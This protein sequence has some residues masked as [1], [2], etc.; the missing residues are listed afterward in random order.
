MVPPV[1]V[2]SR[3]LA[4]FHRLA[5][6]A[7]LTRVAPLLGIA[8]TLMLAP[9]S[10]NL[11]A[12][13]PAI[14]PSRHVLLISVDGLH[15]S[16]LKQWIMSNPSS[17]LAALAAKGT[18]YTKASTSEP[19][20]SF[21]GLLALVTGASPKTTGVY[22]D[23]SYSRV[24]WAPGSNCAG[25]AGAETVY[26]EVLDAVGGKIPLFGSIQPAN[27]PMGKLDGTCEVVYPHSFLQTNTIFNV[28]HD[29]GLYTAW[30]DKHPA[31]EIVRGRQNTGAEDLFT[32][33][34]NLNVSA[35]DGCFSGKDPTKVSVAQTFCYD[36][37]KVQA[38][39]N[40]IDGRD[41]A[42]TQSEPVP[43]I[44]GMNFQA[45]SVAE[46][47]VDS[48]ATPGG[49]MPGTLVFTSQMNEALGDV[50][51]AIGQFWTELGAQG[52]Q[53]STELIITAKHGQSPIDPTKLQKIGDQIT[54]VLTASGTGVTSADIG[55]IT[56]DDVALIWLRDQSKTAAAV[57][58]L[59][60]DQEGSNT[61]HIQTILAG[62]ALVDQFGNP[63]HN[64][65]TP[66]IIVQPIPGTI[67]TTSG[68]KVAE[69]GGFTPDDTHVALL[70]VDGSQQTDTGKGGKW[71]HGAWTGHTVSEPVTTR[72]VAPTILR[73]L[74]IN[75]NR[76]DGVRAEHT[77][78]LPN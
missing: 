9:A 76:L 35:T 12:A 72:Q 24:L 32:P 59:Q 37:I 55:Q 31:Y 77:E 39:L 1:L 69:H 22:Y 16:D 48:Y 58:A 56:E 3:L 7:R 15:A 49:Y 40:E 4:T 26:S 33:E 23:D 28:A 29:A 14:A 53:D 50:D 62:D 27:L 17:N 54:T 45:V 10:S 57:A 66:D 65:R 70:V 11:V 6:A 5:R 78:E 73:Y 34:I 19:S 75:P 42:N 51:G 67:Y 44:F 30:S 20:D 47:L 64:D 68:S 8:A 63:A 46:K 36:K 60:K 2:G 13:H 52:L 43:A 74:G 61:A 38:V 71:E 18:T 41:S 21:P 25:P